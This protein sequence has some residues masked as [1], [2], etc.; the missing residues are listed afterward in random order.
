METDITWW[1]ERVIDTWSKPGQK[2]PV[3]W[4]YGVHDTGMLFC[5]VS[6]ETTGYMCELVDACRIGRPLLRRVLG[7]LEEAKAFCETVYALEKPLHGN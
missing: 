4:A 6:K 1:E 2:M 5:W 7:T 3:A